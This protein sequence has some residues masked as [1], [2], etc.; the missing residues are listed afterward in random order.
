MR[1]AG[2]PEFPPGHPRVNSGRVERYGPKK[3]AWYKLHEFRSN[4]GQ[5]VVG[6]SYG[7]WG[8]LPST[9]IEIDWKGITDTTERDRLQRER[10]AAEA[11]EEAKRLKRAADASGRAWSQWNAGSARK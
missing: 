9:R 4:S 7:V 2:M 10:K 1:A 8:E 5:F 11:E 6:G 3:K